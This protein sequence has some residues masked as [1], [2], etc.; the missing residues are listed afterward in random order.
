MEKPGLLFDARH[1]AAAFG[2]ATRD[3]GA[4]VKES[5]PVA[6]LWLGDKAEV[7]GSEFAWRYGW[8]NFQGNDHAFKIAGLSMSKLCRSRIPATGIVTRLGK[9]P[10]FSGNY[11]A[12]AARATVAGG[13]PSIV[14]GNE[15]HVMI[16][17]I[18]SDAGLRFNVSINGVQVR[19]TR[20]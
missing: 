19:L 13:G 2:A 16:R 14:L 10:D 1:F 5:Q 4:E 15:H 9:L 17:L 8:I 7:S 11:S 20:L 12:S 3:S 6:T 18:A